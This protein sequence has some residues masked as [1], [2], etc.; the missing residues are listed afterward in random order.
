[1]A[2]GIITSRKTFDHKGTYGHALLIAGSYGKTGAAVLGARACLKTGCGLVTAHLPKN[3]VEIMQMAV[4]EVMVTHDLNENYFSYPQQ[5]K[6]FTALGIGPGIGN[7]NNTMVAFKEMLSKL[8]IPTII[9]ADGINILAKNK[10][11]LKKIPQNTILTPHPKEFERL[12]GFRPLDLKDFEKIKEL[13]KKYKCFIVYK[14]AYTKIISP[15]GNIFF[16]TTGNPGMAT[17]GS[18]DVL[19]GMILSLLAM[20]YQPEH[21]AVLGVYLHGMAGDLYAKEVCQESLIASD[22]INMIGKAYKKIISYDS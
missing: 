8:S 4:P 7:M 10:N 3:S 22:I 9:D 17:A 13:A 21:A 14:E 2:S 5:T 12:F 16:N 15:G 11:L 6:P 20:G 1:M 19:T 18:G